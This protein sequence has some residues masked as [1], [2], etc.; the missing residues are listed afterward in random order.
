M[1]EN[2]MPRRRF[3]ATGTVLAMIPLICA[4]GASVAATN[5]SLR[6]SLKYQGKPEG[7]KSCANCAQF[8]AGPT[9]DLGGCKIIPGDTEIS[10]HGY[11]IAW[12][13]K[14]P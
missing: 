5:A 10:P 1:N 9:K 2:G 3:L 6:T 12:T 14:A 8:V 13:K 4:P 11:C 7:D